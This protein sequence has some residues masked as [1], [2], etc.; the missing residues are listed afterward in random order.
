MCDVVRVGNLWGVPMGCFPLEGEGYL[1]GIPLPPLLLVG[2]VYV[3]STCFGTESTN[4]ANLDTNEMNVIEK[5]LG[6]C[7]L[8]PLPCQH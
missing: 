1:L 8:L 2:I 4:T 6:N 7:N 5:T 3:H